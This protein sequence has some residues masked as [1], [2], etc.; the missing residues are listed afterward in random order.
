M[1]EENGHDD[2]PQASRT[3]RD[4]TPSDRHIVPIISKCVKWAVA[5]LV[6]A[7]LALGGLLAYYRLRPNTAIVHPDL[8]LEH[9]VAVGDGTHNS[10]TDLIHWRDSFYM[11]H[12]SS[13][14]HLASTKCHLVLWRSGDA[15]QWEQIRAFHV[16][17]EDIRDPKLAAIGDRL[18]MYVLKN[19]SWDAEPYTTQFTST[20]DGEEW[21]PLVDAQPEG[22]LFW[23]PK[24]RDHSTWYVPAYWHEHGKSILL[25]STDGEHWTEVSTIYEGDRNDETDIE[26]LPDGR[27]IATARLEV[28]NSIFGHPDACTLI[29]VAEPPYIE[30]KR[31]KSDVT[32]LDGP[33]LFAYD[34]AVYAVGRHNPQSPRFLRYYGSILGKKRTA[35]Y[36]VEPDRLLYLSDLPSAGD[37]AYAGV[38]VRGDDLYT[39]YYTSDIARDYPWLMGMLSASDIRMAKVDLPSLAAIAARQTAP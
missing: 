36:K 31:C 7:V 25:Q 28:S 29:A 32:R 39:C 13:P 17:G 24:T 16:P 34:G 10:N 8:T 5:G 38:A 9:W 2:G 12:A 35:L 6:V 15:R 4:G 27:L 14:W 3:Q 23:R 20:H 18:F 30:W 21:A 1:P 19:V 22:W 26:F 11:V 33:N 37:T